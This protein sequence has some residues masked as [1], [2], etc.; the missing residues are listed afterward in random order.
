MLRDM[1]V[2]NQ[3]LLKA[4]LP[5]L[6]HTITIHTH[7]QNPE[8]SLTYVYS[9]IRL[10]VVLVLVWWGFLFALLYIYMKSRLKNQPKYRYKVIT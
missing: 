4:P 6:I 3:I 2:E 8:S 5:P 9:K 7:I 1:L 10:Q